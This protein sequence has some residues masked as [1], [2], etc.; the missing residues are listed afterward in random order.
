MPAYIRAFGFLGQ[1]IIKS[2]DN[3]SISINTRAAIT[4]KIDISCAN[5]KVALRAFINKAGGVLSLTHI[6]HGYNGSERG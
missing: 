2:S 3:G 5:R 4:L 6:R 1:L